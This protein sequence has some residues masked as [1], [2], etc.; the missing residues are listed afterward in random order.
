MRLLKRRGT[1]ALQVHIIAP[2][3]SSF[4]K[5]NECN[6]KDTLHDQLS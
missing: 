3:K 6:I 1:S 4:T 2:K 5:R